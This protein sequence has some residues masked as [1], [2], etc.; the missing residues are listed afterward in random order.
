MATRVFKDNVRAIRKVIK[1]AKVSEFS[2]LN[3]EY[4]LAEAK[5]A[6]EAALKSENKVAVN[7]DVVSE[8]KTK[9]AE[10]DAIEKLKNTAF[11]YDKFDEN[12]NL[13][14]KATKKSLLEIAIEKENIA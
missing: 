7:S 3:V 12:S 9:I 4:D 14:P 1:T 6:H 8:I 5:K 2:R 13:K 11:D 10:Y